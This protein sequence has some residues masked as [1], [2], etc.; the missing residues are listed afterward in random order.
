MQNLTVSEDDDH[1]GASV[2]DG[3]QTSQSFKVTF[4]K[5][6]ATNG[7]GRHQIKDKDEEKQISES[8]VTPALNAA[9]LTL[10]PH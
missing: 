4:Q 6:F 9:Q 3:Q 10:Q 7:I 1:L 8:T 2:Q 5:N